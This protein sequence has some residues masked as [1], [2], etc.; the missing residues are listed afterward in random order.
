MVSIVDEMKKNRLR[1][2]EHVMKEKRNRISEKQMN[3]E[4]R[5]RT[6]IQKTK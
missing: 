2:F 3:V 4:G 1:S 5:R 6:G